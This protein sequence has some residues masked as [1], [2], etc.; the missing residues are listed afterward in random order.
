[1]SQNW[2]STRNTH[3]GTSFRIWIF[4]NPDE[5]DYLRELRDSRE[6]KNKLHTKYSNSQSSSNQELKEKSVSSYS[7]SVRL[8]I[9]Y[10]IA[11]KVMKV[12]TATVE[13]DDS[14]LEHSHSDI[15]E[16]TVES[17]SALWAFDLDQA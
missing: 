8:P 14:S 1:M 6:G 11:H 15:L 3:Y 4:D 13:M 2:K 12:S 16:L 17:D 9:D 7:A 5:G 10:E